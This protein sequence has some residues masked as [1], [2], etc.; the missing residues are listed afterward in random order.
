M[1]RIF[2]AGFTLLGAV[3][4]RPSLN[5]ATFF[6][7][8]SSPTSWIGG[9]QTLTLTN[10]SASRTGNLGA[11]TDSVHLSAGGY[12]LA[13]VGPGLT[14]ARIGFYPGA[15]R[16]PFMGSGPGMAFTAPGRGNNTLTGCFNVLQADYDAT[17]QVAAFAVDFVQYDE[18]N[19]TRWN[20]GSIRFNSAIPAPGP[21]PPILINQLV[22]TNGVVQFALTGP[23]DT[24]CLIQRS[25][26]LL[27]WV[28]LATNA[29]S[30]V[31]LIAI[32][33]PGAMGEAH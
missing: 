20:R 8:T 29:I 7:F 28:P 3:C 32:S 17:G 15:T 27:T 16:W 2:L 33:D 13:I 26:D 9:G 22:T 10:V 18:G 6:Y 1:K 19:L 24:Q 14:L 5:A 31:G 11:Y 21:P 12:E 25:S 4:L 30:P 23:P